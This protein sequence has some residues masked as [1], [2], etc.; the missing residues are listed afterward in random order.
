MAES[1]PSAHPLVSPSAG[2]ELSTGQR[3]LPATVP[4]RPPGVGAGINILTAEITENPQ[5]QGRH[6]DIDEDAGCVWLRGRSPRA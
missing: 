4:A 1:P 3:G 5:R 6:L 2:T